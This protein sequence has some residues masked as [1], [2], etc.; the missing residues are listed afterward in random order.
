MIRWLALAIGGAL[1]LGCLSAPV[2]Y[3]WIQSWS[4]PPDWPYSR[5]FDRAAMLSLLVMLILLRRRLDL[6]GVKRAFG[7]GSWSERGLA[8]GVGL[9]LTTALALAVVPLLVSG[10]QMA[11]SSM[12]AGVL[13]LKLL[14][15][16]PGAILVSVIEESF[17]R[18]L[19]LDGLSRRMM[20]AMAAVLCSAFYAAVHFIAPA[21]D[22]VYPGWG[23]T[24]GFEYMARIFSRYT[25]PAV[26]AGMVGLLLIGLV[27]CWTIGRTRSIYLCIGLHA[28][29]FFV[30]KAAVYVAD[31]AEGAQLPRGVNE[32]YFL[33]GRPW[34]WLSIV[35]V[36]VAVWLLRER[37]TVG[38]ERA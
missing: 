9:V 32:R 20:V 23:L 11:W 14:E 27:L 10:D 24:V 3:S 13:A 15:A 17:F 38:D 34:T 21:K 28:G 18:V 6:G 12:A 30:A 7:L 26:L 2:L 36:G 29:W 5:V 33:I 35:L 22:W 25:L 37:L 16:L 8:F 1:V 31:V 4:S 19:I